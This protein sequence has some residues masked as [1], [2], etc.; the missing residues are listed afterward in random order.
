M[1]HQLGILLSA[2]AFFASCRIKQVSQHAILFLHKKFACLNIV[3]IPQLRDCISHTD[4]VL[5]IRLSAL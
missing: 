3:V 1:L 5:T 2:G 4:K